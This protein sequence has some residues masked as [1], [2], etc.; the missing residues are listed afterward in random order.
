MKLDVGMLELWVHLHAELDLILVRRKVEELDK[1]GV[2]FDLSLAS[3]VKLAHFLI[4]WLLRNAELEC[5]GQS[6]QQA[7]EI[8]FL[9]I[10]ADAVDFLDEL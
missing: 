8:S 2:K 1:F 7:E 6:W 9:Y 10:L 5:F 4:V 3:M